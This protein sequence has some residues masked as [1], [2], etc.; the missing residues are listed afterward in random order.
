MNFKKIS[1]IFAIALTIAGSM[2]LPAF[3]MVATDAN[4]QENEFNA[5]SESEISMDV[6]YGYDGNAKSGRFVPVNV[7]V[8]VTRTPHLRVHSGWKPWNRILIFT[9]MIIR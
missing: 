4:S 8:K 1:L 3:G 7:T 6:S 9:S 5:V 2:K